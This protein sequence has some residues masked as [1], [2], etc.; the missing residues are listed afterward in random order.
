MAQGY[1]RTLPALTDATRP[2]W[3]GGA[4]GELR[5]LRCQACGFWLH[6]PEP[7]CP[8]CLSEELA[9]AALSGRAKVETF[10]INV[11]A[12]GKDMAVPYVIAIVALP[13]QV[14]LRVTTNIVGCAPEAVRIGMAV[15]VVFEQD[16]DVWLPMF[17][18]A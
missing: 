4:A 15:R 5:V 14:G 2:F 7:R 16:E 13:E 8:R 9:P 1:Q 17:T 12:W 10:T 3:T 18:P 6:P 11:K